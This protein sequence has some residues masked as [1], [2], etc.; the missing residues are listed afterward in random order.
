MLVDLGAGPVGQGVALMLAQ[1]PDPPPDKGE[2]FGK[3]S[4]IGLV[5]IL[6]LGIATVL[7]VRSM[8]KRIRKLPASFDPP[9]AQPMPDDVTHPG[10]EGS[11]PGTVVSRT[12]ERAA[13]RDTAVP[14]SPDAG[15]SSD[16]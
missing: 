9:T 8:T 1:N 14:G 15:P 16:H 7:L 11:A 13:G 10:P 4:P 6:V 2:E 5:V 3:A 12:A